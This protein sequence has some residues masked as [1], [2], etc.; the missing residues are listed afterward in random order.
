MNDQTT[1]IRWRNR[2]NRFS[3]WHIPVDIPSDTEGQTSCGLRYERRR[4]EAGAAADGELCRNCLR[5]LA[6]VVPGDM[7]P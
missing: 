5:A 7:A 3:R 4:S 1:V 6:G 2:R